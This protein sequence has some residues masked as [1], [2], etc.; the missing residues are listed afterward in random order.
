VDDKHGEMTDEISNVGLALRI[1]QDAVR[2]V[3]IVK[4]AL[5]VMGLLAA[6]FVGS[7]FF[8][9]ELGKA[10]MAAAGMIPLMILLMV[11]ARSNS[12]EAKFVTWAYT[13]MLV[14]VFGLLISSAFFATP[15]DLRSWIEPARP[16]GGAA[17]SGSA[18]ASSSTVSNVSVNEPTPTSAPTAVAAAP[19]GADPLSHSPSLPELHSPKPSNH[20]GSSAQDTPPCEVSEHSGNI[21]NFLCYCKGQRFPLR[22][23]EVNEARALA[24][25]ASQISARCKP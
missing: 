1:V 3:P 23:M 5:G 10:F 20:P 21:F 24:S 8:G 6:A 7:A 25:I 22:A 4:Y 9:F 17:T 19:G 14:I 2:H 13:L 16:P 18:I 15:L 12:R 11:L